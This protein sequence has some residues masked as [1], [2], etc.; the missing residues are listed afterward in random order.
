MA[1]NLKH[2]FV[3]AKAD[4]VDTTKARPSDWNAAIAAPASLVDG[5]VLK[6]KD[7]EA[8]NMEWGDADK[9][10]LLLQNDTGGALVAGD[11]VHAR[12]DVGSGRVANAAGDSFRQIYVALEDISG[13]A[14]GRFAASGEVTLKVTGTVAR[15][16]YLATSSTVKT[17]YSVG[18]GGST[19]AA[20]VAAFARAMDVDSGG[21]VRAILFGSTQN[22]RTEVLSQVK[23]QVGLW[24]SN[25]EFR[26]TC[27]SIRFVG[28]KQGSQHRHLGRLY[29]G[30]TVTRTIDLSVVGLVGRDQTASFGNDVFVHL[31][32]I[33]KPN[34]QPESN[35][36]ISAVASLGS[37]QNSGPDLTTLG[38]FAGYNYWAYAGYFRLDGS[39]N[40]IRTHWE[41]QMA[42]FEPQ[43]ALVTGGVATTE[44]SVTISNHVSAASG[45]YVL[46]IN[47]LAA[48]ISQANALRLRITTG[49]E[50]KTIATKATAP[51]T[52]ALEVTMPRKAS[53]FFY[54]RQS[55]EATDINLLGYSLPNGD[56]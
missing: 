6:Y 17:A 11:V 5:K 42:W 31:Y 39:G 30:A 51:G 19:G 52:L 21:T 15:G 41:G 38:D 14:T 50:F 35:T 10:V 37:P 32:W 7:A 3:S 24:L 47:A 43:I 18:G 54:L 45:R 48:N 25:T 27:G 4:G 49:V 1:A 29:Y 9:V 26:L 40:I 8:D 55:A 46:G 44:T 33:A 36:D 28:S 23:Q 13:G 34:G 16:D 56:G 12:I 20:V 53:T 22:N 2:T